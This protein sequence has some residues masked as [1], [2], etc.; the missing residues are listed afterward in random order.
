[1]R[2]ALWACVALAGNAVPAADTNAQTAPGKSVGAT[3]IAVPGTSGN[4]YLAIVPAEDESDKS[5]DKGLRAALVE[6]LRR[7]TGKQDLAFAPILGK[8]ASLVQQY[9]FQR[10][11]ASGALSFRAA[12][13]PTAIDTA[14]TE[15]GLPVFGIKTNVVEAWVTEVRGLRS[16]ADYARTLD[17]FSGIRGVRRVD[18][19]EVRDGSVRLRMIVEGGVSEAAALA[20]TSGVVRAIADGNHELIR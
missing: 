9:G 19:A 6:V 16:A 5:R 2:W 11:P 13:D 1:M 8:S 18:V 20:Q 14:L 17:H 4:P 3:T 10:D 12:F 7:A 15:Q